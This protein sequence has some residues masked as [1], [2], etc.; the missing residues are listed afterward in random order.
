[1]SS[2]MCTTYPP[3]HFVS[4][5]GR[6]HLTT[7]HFYRCLQFVDSQKPFHYSAPA[8]AKSVAGIATPDESNRHLAHL[9]L[10]SSAQLYLRYGGW[11]R[12]PS[13]GPVLLGSGGCNLVQ[14]TSMNCNLMEVV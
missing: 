3:D 14:S 7:A 13:G 11:A 8:T 2:G 5:S 4:H 9:R 1:M 6:D 10:V 12:P